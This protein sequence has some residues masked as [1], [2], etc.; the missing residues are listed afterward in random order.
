VPRQS[1][2]P[3]RPPNPIGGPTLVMT[4]ERRTATVPCPVLVAAPGPRC[5]ED[6]AFANHLA[7]R[8][9]PRPPRPVP[10]SSTWAGA[11]LRP[12]QQVSPAAPASSKPVAQ[13]LLSGAT[14]CYNWSHC[15]FPS[16]GARFFAAVLAVLHRPDRPVPP[17]S[18]CRWRI[19]RVA[20]RPHHCRQAPEPIPLGALRRKGFVSPG[21][22]SQLLPAS[23]QAEHGVPR[24][25]VAF[26][27]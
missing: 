19:S 8:S 1:P 11:G 22:P 21:Y 4:G 2:R 14:P 9:R 10:P 5:T 27:H 23:E 20:H 3:G 18:P 7:S 12:G 15:S 26:L 13:R 25:M 6:R 24:D 17:I 16:T